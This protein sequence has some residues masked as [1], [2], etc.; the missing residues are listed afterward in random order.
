M[1]KIG[2]SIIVSD[3]HEEFD[4]CIKSAN[5]LYDYL[6]VTLV[7]PGYMD[8]E[9]EQD[10]EITRKVAEDAGAIITEY[11]TSIEWEH[12]FIDDFSAARSVSR[13][14]IPSDCDWIIWLDSD[15]T[16]HEP[17]IIR[18]K[19]LGYPKPSLTSV[20]VYNPVMHSAFY[21]PR[22]WSRGS[23]HWE[24]RIHE[25]LIPSGSEVEIRSDESIVI[26]HHSASGRE[27]NLH[28]NATIMDDAILHG[29]VSTR[30]RYF[31]TE[32]Q[33]INE[34]RAGNDISEGILIAIE[35]FKKLIAK[36]DL[37]LNLRFRAHYHLSD[38]YSIIANRTDGR[39]GTEEAF[40][41]VLKCLSLSI[42]HGEPFFVMGRLLY[43]QKRYKQA[44]LWLKH[45]T[46]IPDTTT[47]WYNNTTFRTSLPFEQMAYCYLH[48]GDMAT[49]RQCHSI[50]RGYNPKFEDNDA[51]FFRHV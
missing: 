50:A 17:E 45:A 10:I 31:H 47:F 33:Y 2:V 16:I 4:R 9:M 38:H 27:D 29:D 18:E 43:N 5:G 48:L 51:T 6:S 39:V 14:A 42:D 28:R 1:S 32:K 40:H 12:P 8:A 20:A 22:I 36:D 46:E 35:E 19:I 23:C 41:H 34:M 44:I 15:D 21:Q 37:G 11:R 13:G 30:L 25:N 7:K 26:M 24:G 3:K 49:A